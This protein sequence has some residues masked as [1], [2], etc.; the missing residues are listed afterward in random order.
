MTPRS[1]ASGS[2]KLVIPV[3]RCGILVRIAW[4]IKTDSFNFRP[5]EKKSKFFS[6]VVVGKESAYG[7]K[8]F[9]PELT[10]MKAT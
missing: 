5:I 2:K 4:L 1:P 8:E 6:C 3:F 7:R 9:L 10:E